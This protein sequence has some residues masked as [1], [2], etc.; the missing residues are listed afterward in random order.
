MSIHKTA[1]FFYASPFPFPFFLRVVKASKKK[2]LMKKYS[3]KYP[4]RIFPTFGAAKM[5]RSQPGNEPK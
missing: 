2:R 1:Q 5:W 4:H 3:L